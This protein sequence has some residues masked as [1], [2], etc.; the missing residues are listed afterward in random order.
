M[1]RKNYAV[2]LSLYN[3]V[4][5]KLKNNAIKKYV[6]VKVAE[7]YRVSNNYVAAIGY[8][9]SALTA[10]AFD[11]VMNKF[12]ATALQLRGQY[13]KA[14]DYYEQYLEEYPEDALARA[15]LESCY[16]AMEETLDSSEY[17]VRNVDE[18]NSE[19][20]DYAPMFCNDR[21]ILASSTSKVNPSKVFPLNGDAFSNFYETRFDLATGKWLPPK[22]AK[23]CLN[24]NVN[25]GSCCF[26]PNLQTLYY[27][28]CD[29]EK[30]EGNFC[31]LYQAAY[32]QANNT[33]TYEMPLEFG[34]TGYSYGHPAIT[35]DGNTLYF[36]SD[37]PGGEGG[38]DIWQVQ[39]KRKTWGNPRN[40]GKKINTI[41][42]EEFPYVL[43]DSLLFFLLTCTRATVAWIF[44]IRR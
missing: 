17:I 16:Y 25:D 6:Y 38:K 37:M 29:V 21:L 35:V 15:F 14:A 26:D 11:P 27:M 24:S 34:P 41:G 12:Y 10:G 18:I 28:R 32:N 19:D 33:W 13:L 23:G 2:A 36:V 1:R 43:D 39:K 31:N 44:F 30:K 9:E 4:L 22:E 3:E 7:C 20:S 40:L 8:Y 5:P 42:D